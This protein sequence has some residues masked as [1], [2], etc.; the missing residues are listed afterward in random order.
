MVANHQQIILYFVGPE[1]LALVV[2]SG[3]FMEEYPAHYENY[4]EGIISHY[5]KD[6]KAAGCTMSD[7]DEVNTFVSEAY[8][9]T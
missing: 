2:K 7:A 3:R 8:M 9:I 1:G 5:W 6:N 4:C